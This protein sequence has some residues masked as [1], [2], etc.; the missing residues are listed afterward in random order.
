MG[1]D[2]YTVPD[3]VAVE[4][5][6][7]SFSFSTRKHKSMV[8]RA[9]FQIFLKNRE[10]RISHNTFREC[11][12]HF[13]R[14][15]FSKQLSRNTNDLISRS[16]PM[17]CTTKSDVDDP[18]LLISFDLKEK[19]PTIAHI[20]EDLFNVSKFYC[21]NY[22]LLNPDKTKLLVFGSRQED[23]GAWRLQNFIAWIGTASSKQWERFG[24]NIVQQPNLR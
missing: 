12:V 10:L 23:S 19:T 5:T 7:V 11:C 24:R 6:F 21:H 14:Q 9:F 13:V 20:E 4:P 18:K 17:K 3:T 2:Q 22:L 8:A 16:V 15:P 1:Y